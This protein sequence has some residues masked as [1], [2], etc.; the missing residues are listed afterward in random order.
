M[1][2]AHGHLQPPSHASRVGPDPPPGGIF[3][4]KKLQEVLRLR[5]DF[6]TGHVVQSGCQDKVLDSL[7]LVIRGEFLRYDTDAP[8]Y[9]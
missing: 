1:H 5:I 8:S 6:R 4:I 7:E 9:G 3:E 2:E